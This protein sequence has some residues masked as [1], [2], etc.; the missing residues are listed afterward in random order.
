VNK[1][2]RL[3]LDASLQ[4]RSSR[5]R[6][7]SWA[8]AIVGPAL[9]A[10]ALVPVRS[11]VGLA[12]VLLWTV[13][14]VVVTAAIGGVWPAVTAAVL[15]FGAGDFFFTPPYDTLGI[16]PSADWV[17]LTAFVVVGAIVGTAVGV[18]IDQLARLAI[19]QAALRRVATLVARGGPS[20][21]VFAAVLDEV[22][23]MLPVDFA[24]MGRYEPDGTMTFLAV[25]G[26]A[27]PSVRV[28]SPWTLGGKNIAT[29]VFETGRPARL[30][31]FADASGPV[32]AASREIGFRSAVGTPVL[33][34]GR[35]WGVVIV[36]SILERPLPEGIEPRLVNFTE[37]VATAIA[38]AES[39]AEL[40]RLAD[41]QAALRRVA[42]L[43]A[44]GALPEAVF[45]AVL[46]ELG[47]LLRVDLASI[48][49]YEGDRAITWV[50]NW[51][52]AHE[53]FPVGSQRTL[54]GKNL[55]TIVL[56]TGRSARIDNYANTSS[57]PIGVAA[58]D[59]SINSSLAAPIMVEGRIWGLIAAGSVLNQPLPAD[60][61]GRLVSFTELVGTAIANTESHAEL[62]RLAE[63]QAALRRVATLVAGGTPSE[64][65]FAAVTEEVGQL[66]SVDMANLSRYEG[67]GSLIYLAT[68]SKSGYR[69]PVG[70]R[71][72]LGGENLSTLISKTGRP[73]RIDSYSEASDPLSRTLR[74]GGLRSAVG[75]PITVEGRLWGMMGVGSRG[76]QHVLPDTET[77]LAS[78][79]ELVATAIANAESRA[80]LTASRA[81]I[82]AA[83][84][85]ARRRIERDLHDGAQQQLVTLT[86]KLRTLASTIP[87]GLEGIDS[88]IGEIA[89]G[90]EDVLTSLRELS[91]GIHPALLSTGGLGPALKTLGRRAP[92][93]VEVD[94]RLPTRPS[95]RVEV[96]IYYVV[97][98]ALTNVAKHG[99][100][101]VV[102]VEVQARD[103][104]IRVSVSDDGVGGADP[105]QG[106]GL[107]G[108][109]DRADA[110][111]AT[112]TVK[113]FPG[114]GTSITAHFPETFE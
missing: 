23:G 71:W 108:L 38:N 103:G 90:L 9:I 1:L 60:T 70:S 104:G 79:T 99:Q 33:V 80:E 78:F 49:R 100:A 73:G 45:E 19:E 69:L 43:V 67:D 2:V 57:G 109:H 44:G 112:L 111:G 68:W 58:R 12:S 105:S 11:T 35:L 86:L 17:A 88:G 31:S 82:V 51:G 14:L 21:E 98:E 106:S 34:E 18:L 72:P 42:T 41:E 10:V 113:S 29:R 75:A 25:W 5:W 77:R 39:R 61:E 84:D 85:D 95:E 110:L 6:K 62:T 64:K 40:A 96:A 26:A 22:G 27:V 87:A 32:G 48:C 15:G 97:A 47:R 92:I 81:R 13:L 91:R 93:P 53:H 30:D 63:E 8:V 28:G 94:V 107:L 76:E 16:H 74:E 46:D 4:R 24:G 101:S 54:G 102:V 65:L 89:S 114:E 3:L 83:A 37:L 7:A 20:D 56:E 59:A 36:G 66:F 55:G 50:A 52:R